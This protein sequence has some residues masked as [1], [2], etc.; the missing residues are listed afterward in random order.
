[1]LHLTEK[2]NSGFLEC[3]EELLDEK[4]LVRNRTLYGSDFY[5][6]LIHEKLPLLTQNFLYRLHDALVD[7]LTRENPKRFLG[8]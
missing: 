3:F 1:L 6:V 4:S 8:I 2:R 7:K 5:M